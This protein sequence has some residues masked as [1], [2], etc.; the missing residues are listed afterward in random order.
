MQYKIGD[1]NTA[2]MWHDRWSQLPAIDSILSIRE[3]YVAGFSNEASIAECIHNSCWKWPSE[4]FIKYPILN[5]FQVPVLNPEKEDK[6]LWCSS[7]GA[8]NKFSSNQVWKDIRTLNEEMKWWK[9]WKCPLCKQV[10]DSHKHLFFEC[11]YSKIVWKE[12]QSMANLAD[13]KNLEDCMTKLAN[14]PCKNSIWSI[15]RRLCVADIVYHM[16][17]ERNSKIFKQKEESTKSTLQYIMRSVGSRLMTL[18]VKE[19]N[20]VKEVESKWEIQFL[21]KKSN[22]NRYLVWSISIYMVCWI[23]LGYLR[24]S[25]L[26]ICRGP[27]TLTLGTFLPVLILL[28]KDGSLYP[29]C[30]VNMKLKASPSVIRKVACFGGM[31]ASDALTTGLRILPKGVFAWLDLS[32]NGSFTL[33]LVMPPIRA[34]TLN[35]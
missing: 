32:V 26:K 23:W 22:V 20:V 29:V 7:N 16:W 35:F 27:N 31:P 2:S 19:S 8:T 28:G 4:W 18:K 25:Q 14:L 6:L 1:G 24:D 33:L 15:V 34:P 17:N 9:D 3:I 13:I 21:E 10:E 12:V 30:C 11:V 5:Q